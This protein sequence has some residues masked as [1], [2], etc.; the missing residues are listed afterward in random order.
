MGLFSRHETTTDRTV[1]RTDDD[2][3]RVTEVEETHEPYRARMD[4]DRT[5]RLEPTTTHVAAPGAYEVRP[6]MGSLGMRIGLTV[7]GA[8]AMIASA[9][10][11][12]F[13]AGFALAGTELSYGV[14]SPVGEI[15]D[16]GATMVESVGI[17]AIGL[18]AFALLGLAFATGWLT[19]LAGALGIVAFAMYVIRLFTEGGDTPVLE[20]IGLGAWIFLAGSVL[21]LVG[22]FMGTARRVVV[23]EERD[24][25]TGS[26]PATA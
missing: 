18:G 21:A 3:T 12:W 24:V 22:G 5:W 14:L 25:V 26:R 10:L 7:L 13:A 19:R 1:T 15:G 20:V 6:A 11:V 2:G 8:A 17:V 9:F 16:A 23:P 4:E